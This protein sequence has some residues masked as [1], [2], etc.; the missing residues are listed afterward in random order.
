[1]PFIVEQSWIGPVL[2]RDPELA[3]VYWRLLAP[4]LRH[5][6]LPAPQDVP[7]QAAIL[8]A[9]PLTERERELLRHVADM[10]S[11]AEVASEM[12]ISIHTVKSHL[13]HIRYKLAANC[14]GEA[15]RRARQLELI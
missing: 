3:G 1:L 5:D 11:T 4:T 9:K 10:L 14:R 12:H 8:A 2:R 6:Q 15:V 13:K 7:K